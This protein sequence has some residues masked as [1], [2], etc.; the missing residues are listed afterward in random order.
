MAEFYDRYCQCPNATCGVLGSVRSD[1]PGIGVLE[2]KEAQQARVLREKAEGLARVLWE[3][4]GRP[5][6]GHTQFVNQ[7]L[8][9]IMAAVDNSSRRGLD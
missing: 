3:G 5:E 1:H 2:K 9:Q 8:E 4:V 6:G 7:A